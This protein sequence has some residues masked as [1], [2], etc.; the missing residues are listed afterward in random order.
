ML[1][2]EKTENHAR[3]K[4]HGDIS[5]N[6]RILPGNATGIGAL[7]EKTLWGMKPGRIRSCQQVNESVRLQYIP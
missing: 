3:G 1:L 7:S 2:R 6:N 4:N 5:V